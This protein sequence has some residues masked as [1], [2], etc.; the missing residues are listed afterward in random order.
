M[1]FFDPDISSP[2]GC[3]TSFVD[4][5]I[6]SLLFAFFGMMMYIGSIR[7]ASTYG[8]EAKWWKL[9]FIP[10]GIAVLLG[11]QKV[12]FLSSIA[13]RQT[14]LSNKAL[15]GHYIT[16]IVPVLCI[17]AIIFFNYR[18]KNQEARRVY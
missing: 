6:S 17:A 16:L 15:Y 9:C 10:L 8:K 5:I 14:V 1:S 18:K 7:Y 4:I 2:L 12:A 3:P 13:Y 11:L